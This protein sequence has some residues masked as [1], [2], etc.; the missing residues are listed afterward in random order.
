MLQQPTSNDFST[1]GLGYVS[2]VI[3]YVNVLYGLDA[4]H[5]TWKG[6]RRWAGS[7]GNDCVTALELYDGVAA[8]G[9]AKVHEP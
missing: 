8:N 1:F 9:C 5:V 7:A 6:C 2:R 3:C 4:Q